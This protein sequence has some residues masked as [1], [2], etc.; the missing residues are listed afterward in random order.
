V[1]IDARSFAFELRQ[2][3]A[4]LAGSFHAQP[5]QFAGLGYEDPD[6]RTLACLNS[7]LASGRLTL[8]YQGR[9]QTLHTDQAALELGTRRTDH[10]V[11]LL[12]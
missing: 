10:G 12:A 7:K 6:G 8:S 3:G 4:T 2:D 1:T 9:S 5:E 11:T